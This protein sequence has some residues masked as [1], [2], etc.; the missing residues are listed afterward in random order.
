VKYVMANTSFHRYKKKSTKIRKVK[1]ISKHILELYPIERAS[2]KAYYNMYPFC[3]IRAAIRVSKLRGFVQRRK[4]VMPGIDK[5]TSSLAREMQFLKT[6]KQVFYKRRLTNAFID[7]P[8]KSTRDVTYN[9][10][11]AGAVFGW[12]SKK[13]KYRNRESF[14]KGIY[15]K[16]IKLVSVLSSGI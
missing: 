5:I 16:S 1:Y 15:H 6:K 10:R 11:V 8:V 3:G 12:C 13:K 4:Q 7:R 14:I 2:L 9:F